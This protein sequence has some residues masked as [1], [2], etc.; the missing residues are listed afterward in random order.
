MTAQGSPLTRYRRAIERRS[1]VLAE[2]AA[3]EASYLSLT[4]ALGLVAL[5]AAAEDPKFA[6]A[7]ARWLGRLALEKPELTLV[8]VQVA[9]AALAALPVREETALPVLKEL[10]G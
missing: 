9:A 2:L 3:R 8:D 6:R 4:D 1:L 10:C 7:S 5:Y